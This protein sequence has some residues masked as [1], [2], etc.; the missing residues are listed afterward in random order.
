M[1]CF[2]CNLFG[3]KKKKGEGEMDSTQD[4][5][6]K[7]QED[8]DDNQDDDNGDDGGGDDQAQPKPIKNKHKSENIVFILSSL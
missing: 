8:T 1:G 6:E 7:K 2:L 4:W 5:E 3:G